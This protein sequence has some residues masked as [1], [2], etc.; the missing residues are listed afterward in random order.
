MNKLRAIL[1]AILGTMILVGCGSS[2]GLNGTTNDVPVLAQ[3]NGYESL[4]AVSIAVLRHWVRD[5]YLSAKF[6]A[7]RVSDKFGACDGL[8]NHLG[9][10]VI[11]VSNAY[12]EDLSWIDQLARSTDASKDRLFMFVRKNGEFGF[13]VFRDG[14][15]LHESGVGGQSANE[16]SVTE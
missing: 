8:T 7:E 6:V 13:A 11:R 4:D 16:E 12:R 5:R 1:S 10:V 9:R 15:L 3:Q 14:R 2:R